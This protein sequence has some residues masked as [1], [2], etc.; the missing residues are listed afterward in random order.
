LQEESP[1]KEIDLSPQV[2]DINIRVD[3]NL[4]KS[5]ERYVGDVEK[6]G[7]TRSNVD[8]KVLRERRDG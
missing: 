8:P 4:P 3:I 5:L 2:G 6:K 1:R 7:T